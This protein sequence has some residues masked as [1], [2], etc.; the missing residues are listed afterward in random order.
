[1]I[2]TMIGHKG[3]PSSSGGIERHVEEL[4]TELVRFGV[5]VISFDRAWYVGDTNPVAGIERRWSHGWHTKNLDAITHTFTAILL[6]RRDRPDIIHLHGVGPALLAGFARL[7][8]PRAKIIVTFHCVDRMHAK[9]GFF[10]KTMLRIGEWCACRCAHRTIAVSDTIGRYCM[11]A[12][13]TQTATIPNGVRIN[14]S[15]DASHL[16]DFGLNPQGYFALVARLI[17]HKNVHVAIEAH[18]LLAQRRPDL[19]AK[20]PLVVIGGSS[21]TDTYASALRDLANTYPHVK[22]VGEQRGDALRALQSHAV[23]HAIV[24]ASEGMSIALLEAMSYRKPLIVSD[25]PENTDVTSHDALVVRL[26]DA[27][28]LSRAMENML[29]MTDAE[30]ARMGDALYDRVRTNHHWGS[31]AE[32]TFHV[33]QEILTSTAPALHA[34]DVLNRKTVLT[35]WL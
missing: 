5:R 24:S 16:A 25:I 27:S 15:A 34:A 12:Y 2:V 30:R 9:W 8:H 28:S 17:P 7:V 26:N 13:D 22:L 31:I 20:H 3:I 29:D 4:A 35:F 10:A 1:M 14:P 33:Y 32:Q 23:A 18:S 6:A 19:A 11:S 21:F